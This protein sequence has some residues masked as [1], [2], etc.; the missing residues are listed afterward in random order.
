MQRETMFK[1]GSIL[2]ISLIVLGL[3][4]RFGGE[5][6]LVDIYFKKYNNFPDTVRLNIVKYSGTVIYIAGWLIMAICLS[7]NLSRKNKG[8]RFLTQFLLSSIVISVVWVVMEYKEVNFVLQPKLPLISISVLLSSLSSLI[9]LKTSASFKDIILIVTA[10]FFI[11]FSEY[12]ILP[13]Q[14]QY[15]IQDG[16]G[17][18]VLILGWFILF[19]VFNDIKNSE[20]WIGTIS[21][22]QIPMVDMK[23]NNF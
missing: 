11:I 14:R 3:S 19:S 5:K 23:H 21:N 1:Y 18:P 15:D 16:I 22:V 17:L 8:Y 6:F 9:V 10:S 2:S 12:F 20:D 13:L 7:L 4:I